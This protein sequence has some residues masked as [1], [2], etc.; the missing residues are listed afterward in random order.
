MAISQLS[1][2]PYVVIPAGS[3]LCHAVDILSASVYFDLYD[4]TTLRISI[5]LTGCGCGPCGMK[6]TAKLRVNGFN[7]CWLNVFT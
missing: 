5:D 6:S 1:S 4:T 7:P 3:L 2:N